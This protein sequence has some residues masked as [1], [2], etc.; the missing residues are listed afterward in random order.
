MA[1]KLID[2][3][4]NDENVPILEVVEAFLIKCHLVDNKYQQKSEMLY[5]FTPVKYYVNI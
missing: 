5:T 4:K 3:T 2:K 1:Q